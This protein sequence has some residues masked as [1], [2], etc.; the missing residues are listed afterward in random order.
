MKQGQTVRLYPQPRLLQWLEGE[1][2]WSAHL[3]VRAQGEAGRAVQR[4]NLASEL[5]Q[6]IASRGGA[7][8]EEDQPAT[9]IRVYQRDELHP[10]GYVIQWDEDGLL[11]EYRSDAG[12]Y[13]AFVTLKQ[14]ISREGLGWDCFRIEDEPDFPVRGVMLDI[15]RHKVPKLSELYGLVDRM[16]ELKLNHLQLYM[17]GYCFEMETFKDAFPGSTPITAAEL[18]ELD[19]YAAARYIDLMPNQNCLGHMGEWLNKPDFR[20]L[21]EHPDG[22]PLPNQITFPPTTL[23]PIDPRSMDLVKQLFDALLPQFSSSYANVN[24]DE[25]YG[26][27][28]GKSKARC[29]EI[30]AGALYM[31][32]AD[33]VFD[34]IRGH[35]KKPM[36]W[37]DVLA[38]HPELMQRFPEDVTVLD[39]NYESSISFEAH[40]KM[41]SENRIPFYVCPGTSAWSAISGR[42]DNMLDNI[43]D[44]AI[45]GLSYGAGGL[46]VTDWGDNGH[47]QVPAVSYPAYV[48]AAGTGWQ[49][50]HH[51]QRTDLVERYISEGIYRDESGEVGNFL[52]ELGRY[53]HHE[54]SS[55]DNSTY[56]AHLLIRGLMTPERFKAGMDL[57][58]KTFGE[59]GGP[60]GEFTL[61]YRYDE[62]LEWLRQRKV[63]FGKLKLQA[64]ES[65]LVMDELAN[66]LRLI[67][68]GVG[69][70]R[71]MHRIGFPDQA[72]EIKYLTELR[73][74]LETIVREF[75]RLWR[76]RNREGGLGSSHRALYHLLDQ[77]QERLKELN[78]QG[79]TDTLGAQ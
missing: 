28:R 18:R 62:M 63:Q 47:W 77:Y 14:L 51:L 57:L 2:E 33:Q 35:G 46:I 31:E 22:L 1:K 45:H 50:H 74:Q 6:A 53:H 40:C 42:T 70:H 52:L 20:E 54:N 69:L 17:E 30:G 34:V 44:A 68:Q 72:A 79:R 56:T 12:L 9:P 16:A 4:L 38:S 26:L 41:L 29:D 37:G 73:E 75:D 61:D 65:D 11:L 5:E 27:G 13:Y 64:P 8:D 36:M 58:M 78:A 60:G 32:Y 49:T 67:E 59:L 10:Q 19:A 15:G 55:I 71:Y 76:I 39:W 3:N 21:A 23:N 25:P 66:T 24:M 48:Y 43:S 7:W